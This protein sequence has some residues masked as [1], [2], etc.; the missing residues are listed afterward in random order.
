MTDLT[1]DRPKTAQNTAFMV[2]LAVS[3]CHMVNDI[4]QSLL[5]AIYPLLKEN[6]SLISGRSA[7]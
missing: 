7:C 5:A 1:A 3:F 6:Y 4:M 2:I